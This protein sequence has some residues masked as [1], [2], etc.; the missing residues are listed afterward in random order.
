METPTNVHDASVEASVGGIVILR[1]KIQGNSLG[2]NVSNSDV[3]VF[4]MAIRLEPNLVRH[5]SVS[6]RVFDLIHKLY[7]IRHVN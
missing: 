6:K 3:R 4:N 7:I 1:R 2:A 5:L